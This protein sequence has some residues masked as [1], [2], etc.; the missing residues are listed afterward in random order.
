MVARRDA[1]VPREPNGMAGNRGEALT[2]VDPLP[3]GAPP[4]RWTSPA[5]L[6]S[7]R[8]EAGPPTRPVLRTA[9][10]PAVHA[11]PRHGRIAWWLWVLLLGSLIFFAVARVYVRR[12]NAKLAG[13]LETVPLL[14]TTGPSDPVRAGALDLSWDEVPGATSYRLSVSSIAGQIVVDALPVDGT[15]WLPP[16]DALP[17]FVGGEYRWS[18]EALDEAGAVLAKSAEGAFQV[19]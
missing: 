7:R 18:V 5:D 1:G 14:P 16:D 19:R 2:R 15:E 3:Q 8:R 9:V 4:L 17:A 6:P 11:S 12:E 13:P 10:A